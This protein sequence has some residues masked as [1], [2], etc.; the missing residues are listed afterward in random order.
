MAETLGQILGR[1]LDAARKQANLTMAALAKSMPCTSTYVSMIA[2][3][4]RVPSL[5]VLV[6]WAEVCRVPVAELL[7]G[8]EQE[9]RKSGR[10]SA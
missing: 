10:R 5:E 2:N 7:T 9:L 6:R 8:L 3:G 1:R 4:H